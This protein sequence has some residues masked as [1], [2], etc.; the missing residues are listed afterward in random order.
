MSVNNI[1]STKT[2]AAN[3]G[4]KTRS[5]NNTDFASILSSS[6]ENSGTG[7][8]GIFEA[9]SL[10]Y[11]VPVSLLKA[12]AKVESS[13][14]PN[15][16]S[17]CGAMGIMQL[18][19]RTAKSLGVTDAYDPEQNIMGGAKYLSKL[20]HE[21]NGDTGLALA[22]YN[23]GPGNVRKYN[24]IPPFAQ[25]YVDKVMRNYGCD[26]PAGSATAISDTPSG[27]KNDPSAS[28]ADIGV[29]N[30]S[31]MLLMNIYQ[32]Q[33]LEEI[34]GDQDEQNAIFKTQE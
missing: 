27:L 23:A 32:T 29:D 7:L 34:D 26:I 30:L 4:R 12:V 11:N 8:D 15:A 33:L 3:A 6:K 21:Y 31:S 28:V 18:M 5:S 25:G 24:G 1:N 16:T 14:N 13:F 22:A 9:A 10:K 19:P 17:R 20:L 2:V